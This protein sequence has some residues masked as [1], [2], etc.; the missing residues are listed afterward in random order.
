[1]SCQM[2]QCLSR[3]IETSRIHLC[4]KLVNFI[5]S[6]K[7]Q[8]NRQLT[9]SIFTVIFPGEPGLAICPLIFL[10]HLFLDF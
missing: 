1:M 8:T 6:L 3:I 7:I 9:R 5:N 4:L 2:M 10:L